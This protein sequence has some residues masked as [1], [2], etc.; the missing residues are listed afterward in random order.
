MTLWDP[1][2]NYA[3]ARRGRKRR[4]LGPEGLARIRED[5]K[6]FK[7]T[8]PEEIDEGPPEEPPEEESGPERPRLPPPEFIDGIRQSS[9]PYPYKAA[10]PDSTYYIESGKKVYPFY[11]D[12]PTRS[13]RVRA[14]QWVPTSV[15]GTEVVGDIFVA[16][17]RP[18]SGKSTL[19][20]YKNCEEDV[21]KN[22]KTAKSL[23][24]YVNTVLN[25]HGP[26]PHGPDDYAI[27]K[28]LHPD[29]TGSYIFDAGK[30]VEWF[31]I[32]N[33]NSAG[34]DERR[35][36]SVEGRARKLEKR[37]EAAGKT[38]RDFRS[39]PVEDY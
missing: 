27:Y 3:E 23:G 7:E 26:K 24:R 29:F 19:F 9:K 15:M 37:A 18:N 1:E 25:S 32:R 8:L 22:F 21:W 31:S 16:F 4:G 39:R 10:R 20:C 14:M 2:N 5:L 13:T 30:L 34:T 12:G 17:A 11:E 6:E 38:I 33:P 35:P 36:R 28:E